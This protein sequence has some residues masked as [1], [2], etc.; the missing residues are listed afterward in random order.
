MSVSIYMNPI[1]KILILTI[2]GFLFFGCKEKYTPKPR[3][4]FR[5]DFPEKTY[6]PISTG[7]PYQFDIPDYA[8][9]IPDSGNPDKPFWINISFPENKA[10]IHLSYY[11]ISNQKIPSR[12]LL[13]EFMEE[14][15]TLAYKHT[16]KPM[17]FRNRFL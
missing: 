14:T 16:I 8:D 5:I 1:K 17:P 2:S 6:H 10:E 15:R 4:F 11:N 12:L 9:I 13:N 7:F 3:E